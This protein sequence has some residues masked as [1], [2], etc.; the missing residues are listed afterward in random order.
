[1]RM[2]NAA[3]M[4]CGHF[5]GSV[6]GG[7][8]RWLVSQDWRESCAGSWAKDEFD[9][10]TRRL[11]L[12]VGD[13]CHHARHRNRFLVLLSVRGSAEKRSRYSPGT[14]IVFPDDGGSPTRD[15]L[16]RQPRWRG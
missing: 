13:A 3:D 12:L 6:T 11:R 4:Q 5:R 8:G 7:N 9:D 10:G 1:M 14:R 16:D 2:A 15:H